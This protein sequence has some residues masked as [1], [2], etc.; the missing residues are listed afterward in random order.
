MT[1]Y[2]S[3]RNRLA[4][5]ANLMDGDINESLLGQLWAAERNQ[6]LPR[7][8][9]IDDVIN[10]LKVLNT[11]FNGLDPDTRSGPRT[12]PI[13]DDLSYAVAQITSDCL[14]TWRKWTEKRLYSAETLAALI[15]GTSRIAHCW[16]Q[17][18]AGDITDLEEG[19]DWAM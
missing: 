13:P 5:H 8:E 11:H 18:L 17:L 14:F 9:M 6:E 3:T 19:F 15:L 1:A 16:T 7:L 12:E 2:E 10:C 4:N